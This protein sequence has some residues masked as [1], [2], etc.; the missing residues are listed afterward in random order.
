MVPNKDLATMRT[1]FT[2]INLEELLQW[3]FSFAEKIFPKSLRIRY[4][5]F[6]TRRWASGRSWISRFGRPWLNTVTPE[7]NLDLL[8]GNHFMRMV[9]I[10]RDNMGAQWLVTDKFLL[11]NLDTASQD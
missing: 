1:L 9:E 11:M 10:C 4:A 8:G 6:F 2:M 7:Q 5:R 3:P